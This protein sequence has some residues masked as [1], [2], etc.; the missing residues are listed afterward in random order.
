MFEISR[1]DHM[2]ETKAM[3]E[4]EKGKALVEISLLPM[5]LLPMPLLGVTHFDANHN[6]HIIIT[7][8][9]TITF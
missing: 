1:L 7:T 9:T 8:I 3:V 2:Q 5:P 4:I 6:H